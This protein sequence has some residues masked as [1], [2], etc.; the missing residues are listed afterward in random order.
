MAKSR[1]LAKERYWRGIVRHFETSGLGARRFCWRGKDSPSSG[2]IGGGG[3]YDG[4]V[5]ASSNAHG[6]QE[7][8]RSAVAVANKNTNHL[9]SP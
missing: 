5:Q 2:C 8:P 9:F 7:P 4:V 3:H 1:D 6:R